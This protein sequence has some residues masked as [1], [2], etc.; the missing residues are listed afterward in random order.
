MARQMGSIYSVINFAQ[1][2]CIAAR[3]TSYSTRSADRIYKH[4]VGIESVMSVQSEWN[5]TIFG[6]SYGKQ[7]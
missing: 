7:N 2:R 1:E 3:L 6:S 5:T 4:F